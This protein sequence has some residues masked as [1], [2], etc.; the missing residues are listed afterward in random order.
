MKIIFVVLLAICVFFT[1]VVIYVNELNELKNNHP[2]LKQFLQEKELYKTLGSKI[3]NDVIKK[4]ANQ[5]FVKVLREYYHL[6]GN[7]IFSCLLLCFFSALFGF[8]IARKSNL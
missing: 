6:L 1:T 8:L 5:E 7:L 3:P 2:E 4:Y